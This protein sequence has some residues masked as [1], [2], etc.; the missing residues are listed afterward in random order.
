M[1]ND[2]DKRKILARSRELLSPRPARDDAPE[3]RPDPLGMWAAEVPVNPCDISSWLSRQPDQTER[4]YNK[5][6]DVTVSPKPVKPEPTTGTMDA[7]TTESLNRWFRSSFE[8]QWGACQAGIGR[9]IAE[10]C[11][12]Q[13]EKFGELI[14]DEVGQA[15]KVLHD[16]IAALEKEIAS[17]RGQV[18]STDAVLELPGKFRDWHAPH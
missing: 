18:D 3:A 1:F 16:K 5:Q 11:G 7:A 15:D 2:D 6:S 13:L 10:Y 17:L 9:A 12:E 14:G 8:L 4:L